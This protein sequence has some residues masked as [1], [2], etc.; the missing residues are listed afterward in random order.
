VSTAPLR[1]AL[2]SFEYPP[3]T[4][5]GGIG[6]YT[7]HHAR[8]LAALGHEVHVLAG[9][10]EATPLRTTDDDGGIKVH[11]YWADGRLM[12]AFEGLGKY[13]LWWTRQRLQNSWSMYRGLSALHRQHRFDVVEMPECGAEG[14]L[15]TRLMRVPTVVRLH[16]PSKLI[17]P[18]YDVRPE[19]T[20]YCSMIERPAMTGASALTSCSQFVA[21]EVRTKVGVQRSIDVITNGI[22]V[23][24]FDETAHQVDIHE[25]YSL[26]RRDLLMVFTG[27]MEPRKGIHLFPEIAKAVLERHNVTFVLAGADLF[28]YVKNTLMPALAD[29]PLKGSLHWLG[30]LPLGELRP[31]VAAADIFLLPSIWENCPYSCLE[32]MAAGRAIVS[33]RQGGMPEIIEHGVNGLL[34]DA[35]DA[36]SYVAQIEALTSNADLR[37]RL[38]ET[39]RQRLLALHRHTDVA[40]QTVAV[41]RRIARK[42]R[43]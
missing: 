14:T 3:E 22:D 9:A 19:D 33:A 7:W 39:A 15:I 5:F 6:S 4:G 36:T 37:A 42:R 20:R 24:W 27:R 23:G 8:G 18:C 30:A 32:A 40:E 1:I 43:R 35:G 13:K 29:R 17:M 25:K 28:D 31:L 41:Y 38:G 11:R 21:D 12:K 34:A 26:P 2:L 16:S 10:R